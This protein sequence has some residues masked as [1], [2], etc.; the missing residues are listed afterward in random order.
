M[1]IHPLFEFAA[2][3]PAFEPGKEKRANGLSAWETANNL[4]WEKR[5][6]FHRNAQRNWCME[7][8]VADARPG[9]NISGGLWEANLG[10]SYACPPTDGLCPLYIG[11]NMKEFLK[12]LSVCPPKDTVCRLYI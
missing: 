8:G 4:R 11:S 5:Q 10:F 12:N 6:S 3:H 1:L 7:Q 2:F 9:S